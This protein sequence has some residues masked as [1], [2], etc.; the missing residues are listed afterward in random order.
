MKK[1]LNTTAIAGS[2][3]LLGTSAFAQTFA[4]PYVALSGSMAGVAT[5]GSKTVGASGNSGGASAGVI[6]PLGALE[7]GYG[8]PADKT[9]TIT[10]G[11]SYIPF[12]ADFTARS[13]S[14]ATDSNSNAG[15]RT[16]KVKDAYTVFVQPTFE[17]NK[18]AAFFA[19]L[20]YSHADTSLS[21]T[22]VAK[23]GDLEGYGGALGLKVALTKNA[24]VQVEGSYTQF[25]S[26]TAQIE[27]VAAA[28][29][30]D[31]TKVTRTFT[32]SKPELVEGRITLGFKF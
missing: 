11:A 10:V 8:I 16:F 3:C 32:A 15:S 2:L 18:D 1:I 5:E 7:I 20:F 19:K 26:V 13:T 12:S 6:T 27:E 23:P 4:G 14:G 25:D 21:G 24:F 31:T 9:T 28:S 22:A 30:G 17:I 29:A